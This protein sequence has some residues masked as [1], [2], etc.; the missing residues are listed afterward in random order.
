M[1]DL[2][3]DSPDYGTVVLVPETPAPTE[4]PVSD[5]QVPLDGQT[6]LPA[7]PLPPSGEDAVP[8][9]ETVPSADPVIQQID[10]TDLLKEVNTNLEMLI[11][12][13]KAAVR[14][15]SNIRSAMPAMMCMLGVIIGILLLKILASYIRP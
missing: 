12:E 14:E 1:A 6:D 13:E 9:V 15:L 4:I 2:F 8:G 3:T 7:D 10:Y 11:Q 5:Q